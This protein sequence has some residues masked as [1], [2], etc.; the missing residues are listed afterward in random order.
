[1][2]L[3]STNGRSAPVS[4]RDAAL[5]GLADDGGLFMPTEIPT[6]SREFWQNCGSLGFAEIAEEIAA[7]LLSDE[8][9]RAECDRIVRD[10]FTFAV[11]LVELAADLYVLELFHGPTLAFKDFGARFMARTLA[12][13]RRDAAR[14]LTVLVATS[15]D[16]GSAVAH[17]F[18]NVPATRVVVLYPSGQVSHVQ[19]QQLTT[20]GGN[21]AALEVQ[22]SFDDCQ[23]MVKAAFQDAELRA[24]LDLTSANSINI[25]RL[26]PQTFYYA[27]A[28]AQLGAGR[29]EPLFAVPSGNFG[30]LTAGLLARRMGMPARGFLATTNVND[31]VPS[32]LVSGIFAPR[33]SRRT[34]SSAMDV[35]DPSNFARM[36]ALFANDRA[37]MAAEI[38]GYRA[39]DAETLVG[40]R[41]LYDAYGY[42]ADPHTA[43]GYLGSQSDRA[44]YGVAGPRIVLATAHPAKFAEVCRAALGI[45][46][47]LPEALREALTLPKQATPLAPTDAALRDFLLTE[48]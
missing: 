14:E 46:V 15:G 41:E 6:L 35:G 23:R 11:P 47:E 8:I 29:A 40:M 42:V 22:G 30:N 3:Y 25:A 38:R 48:G 4:F 18:H 2:L 32:Y 26:L 10:A 34:L 19:E 21:V 7:T 43:V 37:R 5:R 13:L 45:E 44:E 31:I 33:A 24:R 39:T 1:M 20:L 16:T 12:Y 27:A 36:L 28:F 9:P 17:G